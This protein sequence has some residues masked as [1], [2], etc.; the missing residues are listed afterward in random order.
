MLASRFTAPEGV[1]G[2][3][4]GILDL[5][6]L[7]WAFCRALAGALVFSFNSG[8]LVYQGGFLLDAIGGFFVLRYLISDDEDIYRTLRVF[9]TISIIIAGCMLLRKCID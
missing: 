4:L 6:F 3:R 9:A 5:V 1:F 8:A 2:G 7:V